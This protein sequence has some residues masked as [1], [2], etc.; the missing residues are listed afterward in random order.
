MFDEFQKIIA[1]IGKL[2]PADKA[3]AQTVF[4]AWCV[5]RVVYYVVAGVVVWALGRR[6]I[7]ACFAAWREAHRSAD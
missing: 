7:Q 5:A 2:P 6:L 1:E 3:A 4:V